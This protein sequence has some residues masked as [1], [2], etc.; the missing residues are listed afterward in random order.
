MDLFTKVTLVKV[1]SMVKESW[2]G[3]M[4]RVMRVIFG[5]MRCQGRAKWFILIR[6]NMRESGCR[7]KE[8]GEE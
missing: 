3:K 2:F 8:R 7:T 4:V 5:K 6:N 1:K